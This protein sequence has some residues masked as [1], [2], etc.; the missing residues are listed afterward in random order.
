MNPATAPLEP[1]PPQTSIGAK[2][3]NLFVSPTEVF[4]EI[5]DSP[6]RVSNLAVPIVLVCLSSLLMFGVM[7]GPQGVDTALAQVAEAAKSGQEPA[8]PLDYAWVGRLMLCLSVLLGTAWSALTIWFIGRVLL[9]RRLSFAK[10]LEVACLSGTILVLS[11]IVTG[12]LVLA[13]ADS[14]ARPSLLFLCSGL[15][16]ESPLRAL[17]Q[18]SNVF[19]LWAVSVLAIGLARVSKVSVKEAFFWVLGFWIFA[20]IGLVVLS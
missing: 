15:S 4:D 20:R 16:A 18:V 7:T 17:A 12:L 13:A 10:A 1:A 5:A 8:T 2:M 9:R 3:L 14:S 11:A 19:H 6:A